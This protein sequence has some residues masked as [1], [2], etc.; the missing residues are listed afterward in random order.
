M[1]SVDLGQ[2]ATSLVNLGAAGVL[3][4]V[5]IQRMDAIAERLDGV[6]RELLDLL[7]QTLA[8]RAPSS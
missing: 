8:D 1:A 6:H 7:R 5:A 2:L 3:A 4:Y